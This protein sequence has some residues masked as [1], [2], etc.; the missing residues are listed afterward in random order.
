M[1]RAASPPISR[2]YRRSS[3]A[4]PEGSSGHW[5]GVSDA[6]PQLDSG[7]MLKV[8]LRSGGV[9]SPS[10]SARASLRYGAYP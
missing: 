2:W 1:M 9:A 7:P 10:E 4:Y 3:E 6:S 8:S 5:V